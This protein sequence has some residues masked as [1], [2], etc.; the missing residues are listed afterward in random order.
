MREIV[1]VRA[2]DAETFGRRENEVL[3]LLSKDEGW[4]AVL[5]PEILTSWIEYFTVTVA[6]YSSC[7]GESGEDF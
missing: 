4:P 2:T 3:E 6:P 7:A 5:N 1:V